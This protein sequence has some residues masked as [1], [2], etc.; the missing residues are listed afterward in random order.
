MKVQIL[1]PGVFDKGGIARYGRYQIRALREAFGDEAVWAA[2]IIGRRPDDFEEPFEVDWAGPVPHT[3][4][5]RAYFSGVALRQAVAGS[6]DVVLTQHLHLGPLARVVAR[7]A[8]ARLAQNIYGHEIWSG[9]TSS[10]RSALRATDLVIADSHN[11]V[12]RAT[13]LG[14]VR[15]RTTVVWDCVELD[16]YAPGPFDEAAL[17]GY[18]LPAKRRFRVLFLGRLHPFTRYKGS[19]RLIRL[20]AALPGE[21]EGVLA[22]TGGDVENLRDL[23]RD[24]GVEDRV[25]LTG[26]VHE[27]HMPD[28]YRSADAFYLVSEAG[29]KQGE[30]IPVTPL[31]AMACGVPVVVGNQD[32]SREIIDRD[33]G[34]CCDPH[35]SDAQATYLER[36]RGSEELHRAEREAA[37]E[38][39]V[40]AF[41]YAAFA[42]KTA[43]ALRSIV[44][45]APV[46]PARRDD[47]VEP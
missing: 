19:E 47:G 20:I 17:A 18:G 25:F 32:G 8:G 37:R 23:A 5:S 9:V 35:D 13:E 33:G 2:S 26:A 40:S 29:P 4:A 34:V 38:R 43:E 12:D 15:G 39:A 14:L 6:P 36:L 16:R 27:T 42:T 46:P 30:G 24:L 1:T 41:G 31:E 11:S 22:G 21:F 7:V 10:R 28:I 3:T 45:S 44:D